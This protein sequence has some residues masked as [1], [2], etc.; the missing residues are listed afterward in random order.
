VSGGCRSWREEQRLR[1]AAGLGLRW[2]SRQRRPMARVGW[3]AAA[4]G[5]DVREVMGRGG[6]RLRWARGRW[7]TAP[8]C[9]KRWEEAAGD[10]MHGR[11]PRDIDMREAA[12]GS[13][14]GLEGGGN[15]S[16]QRSAVCGA[17]D[18]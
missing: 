11:C 1:E 15:P 17:G 10:S 18:R 8:T 14:G 13:S 9:G 16:G 7:H 6:W 4:C 5:A 3:R 2:R 12:A